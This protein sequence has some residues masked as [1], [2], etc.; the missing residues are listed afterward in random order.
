MADVHSEKIS[1]YMQQI[2]EATRAIQSHD[3]ARQAYA[4][5]ANIA[6]AVEMGQQVNNLTDSFLVK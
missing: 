5:L 3:G 2:E 6:R 4:R 1:G